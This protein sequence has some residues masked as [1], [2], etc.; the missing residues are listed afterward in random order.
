[1]QD[2]I[3]E[4]TVQFILA[5]NKNLELSLQVKNAMLSVQ[6]ELGRQVLCKVEEM[7]GQQQPDDWVIC[8]S[9]KDDNQDLMKGHSYLALRRNDWIRENKNP[10]H[11][12]GVQL[13]TESGNWGDVWFGVC[14]PKH[15][16][17][18]N[19]EVMQNIRDAFGTRNSAIMVGSVS[20]DMCQMWKRYRF[21]D[22]RQ[23]DFMIAAGSGLAGI[24]GEL[25]DELIGLTGLVDNYL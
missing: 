4:A 18:Q 17:E 22:W 19:A 23:D 14:F 3:L 24:A 20:G 8:S 15:Y 7:I 13:Q 12:S 16:E 2:A 1:M 6:R 21:P 11:T 9:Y 10:Q 25:A 5:S